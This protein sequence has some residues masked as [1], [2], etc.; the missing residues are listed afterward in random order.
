MSHAVLVNEGLLLLTVVLARLLVVFI[1]AVIHASQ[2][3]SRRLLA[4]LRSS[5]RPRTTDTARARPSAVMLATAVGP[6]GDAGYLP[7][8]GTSAGRRG[9]RRPSRLAWTGS[10]TG[11][12]L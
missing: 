5:A 8:H 11:R 4:V 9:D 6:S 1:Y 3:L 2:G 7:T 10:R 12:W